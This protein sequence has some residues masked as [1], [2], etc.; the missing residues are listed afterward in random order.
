MSHGHSTGQ[1]RDT[2]SFEEDDDFPLPAHASSRSNSRPNSP[3]SITQDS[4]P[5]DSDADTWL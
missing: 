3:P 5:V 1:Y 4:G 2:S